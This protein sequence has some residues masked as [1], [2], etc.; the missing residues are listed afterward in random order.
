MAGINLATKYSNV[1]DER[2]T[3]EAQT[4]MIIGGKYDFTGE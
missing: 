4:S 2:W 1:V 3:R